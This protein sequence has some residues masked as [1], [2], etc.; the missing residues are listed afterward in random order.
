[1]ARLH[2]TFVD[3]IVMSP[4]LVS[5]TSPAQSLGFAVFLID[6]FRKT[7]GL[8]GVYDDAEEERADQDHADRTGDDSRLRGHT[9]VRL[10]NRPLIPIARISNGAFLFFVQLPPGSYV[11]QVRSPYYQPRDIN[12]TLPL[13]G[14]PAFPN[15]TLANEDLPLDAAAQPAAYRAQRS[16]VTLVPSTQ[17]QFEASATLVRGT[18]RSG[19]TPLAGASVRRT[20]DPLAYVTDGNGDYV[21]FFR[22]I[23]GVGAPVGIDAT[24]PLHAPV[25]TSVQ[26]F[27]GLTSLNDITMV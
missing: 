12:L 18:V 20:G 23:A 15:I 11:V 17:Y 24:H 4:A 14:W 9:T 8:V 6:A 10:A 25:N 26:V 5:D 27:R 22:D 7:P 13:A 1:M 3:R 2:T 19:G 21:L 16:A